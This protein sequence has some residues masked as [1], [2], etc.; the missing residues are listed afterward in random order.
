M[1]DITVKIANTGLQG[2]QGE[3]GP[4]G[5]FSP[6]LAGTVF[7]ASPNNGNIVLLSYA[8]YTF[9]IVELDN[10]VVSSG[11]ISA[12][13]SINGVPVTGID[14]LPVTSTPQTATATA[15]NIVN[16]GD[17]LTLSLTNNSSSVEFEFTM[18]GL[19]S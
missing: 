12:T 17:R 6:I 8:Q 1:T 3:P 7:I 10:L 16:I 11:T 9:T 18:K 5:S 19:T 14:T 2:P 15:A 4:Q 13:I